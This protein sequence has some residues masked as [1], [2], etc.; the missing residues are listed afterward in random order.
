MLQRDQETP[1]PTGGVHPALSSVPWTGAR[2]GVGKMP[3]PQAGYLLLL[4][5]KSGLR[6]G[7]PAGRG[8]S[9]RWAHR[10]TPPPQ[11]TVQREAG[12]VSGKG[13]VPQCPCPSEPPLGWRLPGGQSE[14]PS[15]LSLPGYV[16]R[17]APGQTLPPAG[18]SHP[19]NRRGQTT[20]GGEGQLLMGQPPGGARARQWHSL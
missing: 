18:V 1:A 2:L 9:P 7:G 17:H 11:D 16:G 10:A 3:G 19:D 4:T 15:G 6:P 12:V 13:G 8:L 20:V 14:A 5:H